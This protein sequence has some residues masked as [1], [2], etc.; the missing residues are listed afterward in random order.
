MKYS[1]VSFLLLSFTASTHAESLKTAFDDYSNSFW[2]SQLVFTCGADTFKL[3]KSLL[4]KHTLYWK[5]GLDWDE[6]PSVIVKDTGITFGGLVLTE[7]LPERALNIDVEL[8]IYNGAK[9]PNRYFT[10][11]NSG[12]NY[13]LKLTVDFYQS[14]MT[15]INQLNAP[16]QL[17][18][19]RERYVKEQKTV[20]RPREF[21]T[22]LDEVWQI[23]M[24]LTILESKKDSYSNSIL[25]K[26]KLA[27]LDSK[28]LET[29]RQLTKA[30]QSKKTKAEKKIQKEKQEDVLRL[31]EISEAE[32]KYQNGLVLTIPPGGY[33]KTDFCSLAE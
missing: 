8:P 18:F 3:E 26:D 25:Y 17:S 11:V 29:K 16:H 20:N 30:I 9:N 4:N 5:S 24:E 31:Q 22:T 32:D 7:H 21:L 6:L 28:I 10:L 1:L 12:R 15:T 33:K 19:N 23:E 14:L 27:S 13:P 2:G